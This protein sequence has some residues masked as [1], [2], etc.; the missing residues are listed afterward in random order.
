MRTTK[1]LIRVLE[2]PTGPKEG[3]GGQGR[4]GISLSAVWNGVSRTQN[5]MSTDL[6][7]DGSSEESSIG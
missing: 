4:E 7:L 5:E 3:G 6:V 2:I 1:T